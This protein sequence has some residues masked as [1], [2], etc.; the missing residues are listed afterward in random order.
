MWTSVTTVPGCFIAAA[1]AAGSNKVLA[2]PLITVI[3]MVIE[4]PG[5]PGALVVAAP[6]APLR[7][8]HPDTSTNETAQPTKPRTARHDTTV[9]TWPR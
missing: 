6:T 2:V 3:D 1:N 8:A 7:P 9:A 5:A 4:G